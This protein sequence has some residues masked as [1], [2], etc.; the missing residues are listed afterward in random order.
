MLSLVWAYRVKQKKREINEKKKTRAQEI[1]KKCP[2]VR[3]GGPVCI[4]NC[5]GND[6]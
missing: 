6:L 2:K 3:E 5:G 4:N 1:W